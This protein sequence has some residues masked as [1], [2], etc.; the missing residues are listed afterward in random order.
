MVRTF[1]NAYTPSEEVIG[2]V[3]EKIM[4]RSAFQ[5]VNPVDPFC[6]VWGAEF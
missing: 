3:V 1:I 5:G 4:G 6:G 2:Q